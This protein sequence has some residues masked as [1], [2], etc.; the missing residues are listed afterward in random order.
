MDEA[1]QHLAGRSNHRPT[2]QWYPP[3]RLPMFAATALLQRRLREVPPGQVTPDGLF[4]QV[5]QDKWDAASA[6]KRI[7]TEAHEISRD[8]TSFVR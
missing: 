5:E 4:G 2:R 8:L 3:S 6:M 7:F 1:N